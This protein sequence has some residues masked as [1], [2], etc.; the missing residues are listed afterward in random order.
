MHL[1]SNPFIFLT[2]LVNSVSV[3]ICHSS[4][5]TCHFYPEDIR[6]FYSENEFSTDTIILFSF[7]D[8]FFKKFSIIFYN[9]NIIVDNIFSTIIGH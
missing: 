7:S 9:R 2:C 1:D 6:N 8:A 4:K 3:A 5:R